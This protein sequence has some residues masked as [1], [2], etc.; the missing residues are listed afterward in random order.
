MIADVH[1]NLPRGLVSGGG[2]ERGSEEFNENSLFSKSSGAISDCVTELLHTENIV[3]MQIV[4][5]E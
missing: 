2:G 5:D 3:R 1:F 4:P